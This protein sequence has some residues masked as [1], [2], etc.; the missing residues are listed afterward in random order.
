MSESRRDGTGDRPF[1]T[2]NV[3]TGIDGKLSPVGGG[4]V[5]FGSA[6]DRALMEALRARAD[7]VLIGGGTLRTEDPPLLIRDPEVQARRLAAKGAAHPLN[8]TLGSTLPEGLAEM[9]FFRAPETEKLVFTTERASAAS[10][11]MAARFA[12][13]EVVAPDESGRVDLFEVMRRLP[14]LGVRHL[15][16]EGGG[17]LNFS[18][19]QAGLIDEIHLT[20]CPFVFGGR[21]APTSFDGA[22]FPKEQVRKLALKEHRAGSKGE[23]FLRYEVLAHAPPTVA[24]SRMFRKGFEIS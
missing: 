7:G 9:D 17:E 6:E 20:L 15:L 8:I 23:L 21:T 5:N 4:K 12:R 3:A 24:P 14:G 10:R 2:M 22:G 11:A 18:M 1:V 16:L 19:L 13:V